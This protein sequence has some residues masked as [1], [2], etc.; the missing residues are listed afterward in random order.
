MLAYSRASI[1]SFPRTGNTVFPPPKK[2]SSTSGFLTEGIFPSD[3]CLAL[4]DELT[5]WF[6]K[7]KPMAGTWALW[8]GAVECWVHNV[9]L[10]RPLCGAPARPGPAKCWEH[11]ILSLP[12]PTEFST[13]VLMGILGQI[14]PLCGSVLSQRAFSIPG[15]DPLNSLAGRQPVPHGT[16]LHLPP[17]GAAALVE[18]HCKEDGFGTKQRKFRCTLS[19]VWCTLCL[20]LGVWPIVSCGQ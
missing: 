13:R 12:E 19:W 15:P 14:V 9:P 6:P 1:N 18:N 10:N 4:T 5:P 3:S 20:F 11:A 17:E 2:I 16:A 8:T 7:C